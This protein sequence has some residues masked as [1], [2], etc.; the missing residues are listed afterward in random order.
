MAF[1]SSEQVQQDWKNMPALENT[2]NL[3][4]LQQAGNTF[5]SDF[6]TDILIEEM[7]ELTQAIIKSRRNNGSYCTAEIAEETADVI[8]CLSELLIIANRNHEDSEF[9][10]ILNNTMNNKIQRLKLGIDLELQIRERKRQNN[11]EH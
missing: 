3:A 4:V 10:N 7:A 5:G 9:S 1:K 2:A 11:L 6:Q 8:I